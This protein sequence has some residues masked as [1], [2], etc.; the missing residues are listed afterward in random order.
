MYLDPV[1]GLECGLKRRAGDCFARRR[2]FRGRLQHPS[3]AQRERQGRLNDG[4]GGC[5][6]QRNERDEESQYLHKG[7]L[8]QEL[9]SRRPVPPEL[10]YVHNT[11]INS[12]Q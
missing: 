7:I 1:L 2:D 6:R 9:E 12:I 3:F 5:D 4:L 10:P 8:D 11:F